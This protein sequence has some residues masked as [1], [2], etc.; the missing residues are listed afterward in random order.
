MALNPYSPPF[1]LFHHLIQSPL[2]VSSLSLQFFFF[3]LSFPFPFPST[4]HQSLYFVRQSVPILI[5]SH[6]QVSD[7]MRVYSFLG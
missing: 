1:P 5:A 4:N 7:C 2:T 3:F 6:L